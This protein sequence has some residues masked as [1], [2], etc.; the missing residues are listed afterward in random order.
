M[1]T[2]S[3][4]FRLLCKA[5]N[6]LID[7]NNP[8]SIIV[9]YWMNW[10][11]SERT[12]LWIELTDH[13]QCKQNGCHKKYISTSTLALSRPQ[14]KN[15]NRRQRKISS[16]YD[17]NGRNVPMLR[18]R[19]HFVLVGKGCIRI[20]CVF[21]MNRILLHIILIIV[22]LFNSAIYFNLKIILRILWT[23]PYGNII[24]LT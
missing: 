17:L 5:M 4:A 12:I 8:Q 2:Y 21:N 15:L 20:I 11:V 19:L 7:T 6:N 16:V 18:K 22:V 14:T 10:I 9:N 3:V 1:P 24:C 23:S 13:R